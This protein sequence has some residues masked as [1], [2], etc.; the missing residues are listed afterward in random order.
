[1]DSEMFINSESAI[2]SRSTRD[3][4][5]PTRKPYLRANTGNELSTS[6]I[7]IS[8]RIS[9]KGNKPFDERRKQNY[10]IMNFDDTFQNSIYDVSEKDRNTRLSYYKNYQN[11]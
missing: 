9:N 5:F 10:Y 6:E 7:F 3:Y 11:K 8:E 2:R 4:I 1:M